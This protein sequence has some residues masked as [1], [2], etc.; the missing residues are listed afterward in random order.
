M[1]LLDTAKPAK[2]IPHRPGQS[3]SLGFL[4]ETWSHISRA[5]RLA[6]VLRCI[7]GTGALPDL[8]FKY[9]AQSIKNVSF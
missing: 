3:V 4:A 9:F 5:D 6:P 8:D 7:Q 1:G 2:S